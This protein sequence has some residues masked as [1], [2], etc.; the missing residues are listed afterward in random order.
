LVEVS[1]GYGQVVS[2]PEDMQPALE[3]AVKSVMVDR[4][5]A[6]INVIA[7]DPT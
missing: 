5:Q 6:L 4:R 7:S 3:R 2:K 1:G